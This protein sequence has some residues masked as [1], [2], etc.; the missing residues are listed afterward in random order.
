MPRT[1]DPGLGGVV[2]GESR[3]SEVGGAEGTLYFRGYPAAELSQ[4]VSYE[5]TVFLL[6]RGELPSPPELAALQRTLQ[7]ARPLPD[8]VA[9]LASRLP[10]RMLPMEALRTGISLLG[11]GLEGFPP[12]E[13]ELLDFVA[14]APTWLTAWYRASRGAPIIE[15]SADLGHVAN[16]LYMLDGKP[17][18]SERIRALEEYFVLLSDHGMNAST[19]AARVVLATRSDA[20]SAM[21]AGVGALKG[22]LHG[23]APGLVL[24][25]LD[26]VGEPSRADRWVQGALARKERLMGLGHRVYQVKDP[27]ARRLKQVAQGIA[28]PRRLALAE[29]VE[30]AGLEALRRAHPDRPLYTNVEFWAGV[31]LEAVGLPRELLPATFGVARTA[32]WSAHLIEQAATDRIIRPDVRYVGPPHRQVPAS[33]TR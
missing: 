23:G 26:A 31:V 20:A 28:D 7:R 13:E 5:E 11:S 9:S 16:Y 6:L 8:E 30:R 18:R 17:P 24:D 25:M 32:G 2:V 21:A 27:R 14:R 19:F 10:R 3:I 1:A 4:R 29:A 33:R 22:P 15:P 12:K